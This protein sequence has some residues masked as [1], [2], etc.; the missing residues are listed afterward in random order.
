[1]QMIMHDPKSR[2]DATG[3]LRHPYFW[4]VEQKLDFLCAVSDAYEQRKQTITNI[5]DENAPRTDV[6]MYYLEELEALQSKAPNVIGVKS[7]GTLQ[8]WLQSLPKS[9]LKEMGKQRKYT[10]TKM[11]DLLR[12]IRNKK[13]H[14]HD[15]PVEVKELM[16]KGPG[17]GS[18][19]GSENRGQDEGYYLF[20]R[21]RFPSL[22]V[23]CHQL[24]EERG[25]IEECGLQPYY[26]G[27]R[28]A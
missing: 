27:S 14:F 22:L 20:W 3:V 4:K 9:F 17:T 5:H 7:N 16:I 18:G 24:I 13:N 8:D 25:L 19:P 15:L 2:P 6:E 12:V 1:M 23:N 28:I 10:G 26:D 11:I 21:D